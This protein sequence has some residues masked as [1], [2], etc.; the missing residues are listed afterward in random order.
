MAKT[1]ANGIY[2]AS[3]LHTKGRL[4]ELTQQERKKT[5]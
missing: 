4:Q 3:I 2:Q 5:N 1:I